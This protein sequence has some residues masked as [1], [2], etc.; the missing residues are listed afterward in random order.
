MKESKD[1]VISPYAGGLG[2]QLC[3]STLPEMYARKGHRV[4]IGRTAVERGPRNPETQRLVW[5]MNPFVSGFVDEVGKTFTHREMHRWI[6]GQ[7][8]TRTLVEA[9]EALHGFKP[10]HKLA[11]IYYQPKWRPRLANTIFADPTSITQAISPEVFGLF[12]DHLCRA[13]DINRSSIVLLKSK[14]S[15][16]HGAQALSG[17]PVREV[18]DIF[19]Y[20]DLIASCRLF[21]TSESGGAILGSAIRGVDPRPEVFSLFTTFAFNDRLFQFPN[22]RYCV[23]GKMTGDYL[24]HKLPGENRARAQP[25]K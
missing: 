9:M 7:I 19:E 5:E 21:I 18:S 16:P 25:A 24:A 15:G 17:N 1:V 11:K 22:V 13:R 10:T 20:C 14:Y 23:T 12:I 4:F 3:F 8:E 2:D 6:W